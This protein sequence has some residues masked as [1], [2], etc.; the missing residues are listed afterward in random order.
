MPDSNLIQLGEP[1][2]VADELVTRP[3]LAKAMHVSLRTVDRLK[4]EGMPHVTWGRH[5]VRFRLREAMTWAE[6]HGRKAA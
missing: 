1:R 3:E 4:A 5:L 2:P 6:Q